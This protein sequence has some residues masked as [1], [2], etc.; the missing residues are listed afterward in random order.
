MKKI[1]FITTLLILAIGCQKEND[2]NPE[3]EGYVIK[4]T[5]KALQNEL[6]ASQEGWKL[7]YAATDGSTGAYQ[8]LLKFAA[9]GSVTMTSDISATTTPTVSQ[10]TTQEDNQGLILSFVG[11][12][13][14]QQLA[15]AVKGE[16]GKGL[17][18]RVY[19]FL[20]TRKEGNN[21]LFKNLLNNNP[22]TI[23]FE[24]A[25]ANDWNSIKTLADNLSPITKLTDNYYLKV[26]DATS[27]TIYPIRF[28]NRVLTVS[29]TTVAA[30][31]KATTEGLAFLSPLT[32]AGK[33]F[34]SLTRSGSVATPTYNATVDG[35]SVSLFFSM[36]SPELLT[37]NDYQ[38]INT[39]IEGVSI[40]TP[41][42][43]NSEYMSKVFYEDVL[44]IN[45]TTDLYMLKLLF[46]DTGKCEIQIGHI[47]RGSGFALI[48]VN[49]EYEL[50]NNRIYLK[51]LDNRLRTED[52][53]IWGDANN[54]PI[55]E[56]AQRALGSV[57][58]LGVQGYYIKKLDITYEPLTDNPV[59][60]LQSHEY[61][62]YTFPAW[63]VPL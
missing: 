24:P 27:S 4:T 63:G 49:C 60:Y 57:Y 2:N 21:L 35:I 52:P 7:T 9:D 37:S 6:T 61:P 16:A 33:S 28:D 14:L 25:T 41:N 34:N 20:Y 58:S 32:I 38:H 5:N 55:L 31:A 48:Q 11:Q 59:Y 15:E 18:G 8:F 62:L 3:E 19:Q 54:E 12:N 29:N 26:S 53:D 50:R 43:K 45:N 1:F 30:P 46:A 36:I 10:Y 42:L 39:R 13:Y 23:G 56:K 40:L 44:K 22:A 17:S 51:N 47:F